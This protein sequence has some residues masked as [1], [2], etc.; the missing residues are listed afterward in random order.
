MNMF[1]MMGM[2]MGTPDVFRIINVDPF[3]RP[4]KRPFPAAPFPTNFRM[5]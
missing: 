5:P 4:N 1:A 2:G 3:S